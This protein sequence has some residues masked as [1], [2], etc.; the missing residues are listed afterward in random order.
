MSE[1]FATPVPESLRNVGDSGY[2]LVVLLMRRIE[3][4][5]RKTAKDQYVELRK[6]KKRS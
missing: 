5:I 1:V 2:A 6:C 4:E 3:A